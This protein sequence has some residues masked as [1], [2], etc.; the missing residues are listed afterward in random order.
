M[1]LL[2]PRFIALPLA[3]LLIIC[4]LPRTKAPQGDAEAAAQ[5]AVYKVSVPKVVVIQPGNGRS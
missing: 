3:A 1:F 5:K 2:S 4:A